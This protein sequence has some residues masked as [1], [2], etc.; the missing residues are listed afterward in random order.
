ME[1][2]F[3]TVKA[4]SSPTRVKILNQILDKDST[5]TQLSNKLGKSKSTVSSHLSKLQKA[6]LIQ[7]DSK[8]GRRRVTY[9]P[10]SKAE[11]IIQGK[12]R[13][14]KFSFGSSALSALAGLVIGGYTLMPRFRGT[15]QDM[16]TSS[17][18]GTMSTMT[19]E[20]ADMSAEAAKAASEAS[21][22]IDFSNVLFSSEIL[23]GVGILF[24]GIA[25]FSFIYGWTMN[26]L[27][28]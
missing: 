15:S 1:I 12:E 21:P 22:G 2:N 5:P 10:T 25:V 8:E 19:A 6:E 26:T 28:E 23:L 3:N 14:V 16:A 9:S 7:K 18:T 17:D 11:A 24:L 4:L 13:K 27:E 20:S